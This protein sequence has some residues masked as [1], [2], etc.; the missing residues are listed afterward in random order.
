MKAYAL[1]TTLAEFEATI[2]YILFCTSYALN[3]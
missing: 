1:S 3:E 2:S